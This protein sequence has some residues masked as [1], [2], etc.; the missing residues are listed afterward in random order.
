M[1]YLSWQKSGAQKPEVGRGNEK[2]QRAQ[3]APTSYSRLG[4][5][6][7]AGCESDDEGEAE[8]VRL[9]LMSMP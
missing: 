9:S 1:P 5:M 6:D 3:P 2:L 8:H 4:V 7:A